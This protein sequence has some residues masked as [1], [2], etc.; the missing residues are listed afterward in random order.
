MSVTFERYYQYLTS[1][2]LGSYVLSPVTGTLP[3]NAQKRFFIFSLSP[4]LPRR[5]SLP[6][7][8]IRQLLADIFRNSAFVGPKNTRAYTGSP[9]RNDLLSFLR[10]GVAWKR[11]GDLFFILDARLFAHT[12]KSNSKPSPHPLCCDDNTRGCLLVGLACAHTNHKT[13]SSS[14]EHRETRWLHE[15]WFFGQELSSVFFFL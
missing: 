15:F 9:G 13:T 8:H 14:T 10:C 12:L 2:P 4:R 11:R 6:G 3:V 1:P 7:R 5:N